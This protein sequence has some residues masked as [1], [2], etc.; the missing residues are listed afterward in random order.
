MGRTEKSG[1]WWDPCKVCVGLRGREGRVV[2]AVRAFL[3]AECYLSLRAFLA[4]FHCPWWPQGNPPADTFWP[5]LLR[6]PPATFSTFFLLRSACHQPL[7]FPLCFWC[8]CDSSLLG[9]TNGNPNQTTVCRAR[10]RPPGGP[11]PC[12][13]P[14]VFLTVPPT[15]PG[16]SIS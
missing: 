4:I 11:R 7:L 13:T 8:P 16:V 9:L 2:R 3:P 6:A 14:S 1:W 15:E 5:V 12:P 10:L